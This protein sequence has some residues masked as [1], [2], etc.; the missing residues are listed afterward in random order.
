MDMYEL[1]NRDSPENIG[2]E[3]AKRFKKC[4][5][6][7][8][9]TQKQLS[10]RSLVPCPTISKFEQTGKISLST[11][12]NLCEALGLLNDFK[13]IFIPEAHIDIRRMV[14]EYP[15]RRKS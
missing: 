3:I 10:E 1:L 11:L 14:D 8:G 5:K 2:L 9:L 7:I 6:N 12:L 4:R 15:E 13:K